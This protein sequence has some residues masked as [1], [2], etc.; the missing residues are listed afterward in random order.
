MPNTLFL[1][2]ER[3]RPDVVFFFAMFSL[4]AVIDALAVWA[5]CVTYFR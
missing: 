3:N 5:F 2:T 4:L 1:R